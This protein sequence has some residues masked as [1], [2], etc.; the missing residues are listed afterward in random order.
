M[1]I[2]TLLQDQNAWIQLQAQQ[3][4]QGKTK[5]ECPISH[6]IQRM[7][8]ILGLTNAS[9]KRGIGRWFPT[10]WQILWEEFHPDVRKMLLNEYIH[11]KQGLT[12]VNILE[13][14]RIVMTM[15]AIAYTTNVYQLYLP[16][17][18]TIGPDMWQQQTGKL[19]GRYTD[20]AK[21]KGLQTEQNY[22]QHPDDLL[23]WLQD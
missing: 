7:F 4:I 3:Y 22:Q 16:P 18:A 19:L 9:I 2:P 21:Q 5:W 6:I 14:V 13:L 1:F 15:M 8:D 20:N 12:C 11:Y 23:G 17:M 10:L